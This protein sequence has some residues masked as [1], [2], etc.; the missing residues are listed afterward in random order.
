MS[1]T[2]LPKVKGLLG[3]NGAGKTTLLNTISG[4]NLPTAGR[5]EYCGKDITRVA[6]HERVKLGITQI[7]EGRQLFPG[8]NSAPEPVVG[9]VFRQGQSLD[10]R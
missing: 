8:L 6:S 7:P 10:R 1:E 2:V 9:V 5:I 4:L 3:G